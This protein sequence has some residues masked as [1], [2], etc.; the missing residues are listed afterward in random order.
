MSKTP[1]WN[2]DPSGAPITEADLVHAILDGHPQSLEDLYA[3]A[4]RAV[5]R[6]ECANDPQSILGYCW[7]VVI[8]RDWE[9][10]RKRRRA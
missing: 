6:G 1:E 4:H 7:D 5:R 8:R 2:R 10:E 9:F 3:A